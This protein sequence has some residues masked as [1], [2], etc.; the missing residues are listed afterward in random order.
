MP[1]ICS[2]AHSRRGRN[3]SRSRRR[4]ALENPPTRGETGW[5]S[6]PP[7]AAMRSLPIRLIS[8]AVL[9]RSGCSVAISIA[10]ANP[11]KSGAASRKTWSTWL[12]IH[13]PQY[14]RRRRSWVPSGTSTPNSRSSPWIADIWYAT[15]QIPQ[16]RG[17][18][19]GTSL[20]L[21]PRRNAS[22]K[23]GGS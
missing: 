8:S 16:I 12:S 19:S 18:M 23:R 2:S 5:I 21:R 1:G 3:G 14:R 17:T 7:I 4:G 10:F 22:K 13:S 6:R 20:K 9:T 15:G 11:R